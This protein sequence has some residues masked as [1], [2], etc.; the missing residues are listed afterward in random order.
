[1]E[2]WYDLV[3]QLEA[4]SGEKIFDKV[5]RFMRKI[6]KK[7]EVYVRRQYYKLELFLNDLNN[8]TLDIET[9]EQLVIDI[10]DLS[11]IR[12]L[13]LPNFRKPAVELLINGINEIFLMRFIPLMKKTQNEKAVLK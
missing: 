9:F 5:N 4:D 12:V 13:Q 2:T 8:N 7:D 11:D 3:Y 1:M 10:R 6:K